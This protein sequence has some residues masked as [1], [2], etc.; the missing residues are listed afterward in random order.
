MQNGVTFVGDNL[1]GWFE[2]YTAL[3][4][5]DGTSMNV[6]G[7]T[8]L[9]NLFKGD[10]K[11]IV[12]EGLSNWSVHNVLSYDSMFE[13]CASVT[14]IDVHGWEMN[15][16]ATRVNM[17]KGL[18][19]IISLYL[20]QYISLEGTALFDS[21][22]RN[23]TMGSWM[24]AT[25][26]ADAVLY[27]DDP[28]F[29]SSDDLVRRYENP[30]GND[31]G[32]KNTDTYGAYYYWQTGVFR[33]RFGENDNAWWSYDRGTLTFGMDLPEVWSSE[34]TVEPVV[35]DRSI[36]EA[37]TIDPRPARS[38]RASRAR[39]CPGRRPRALTACST[40]GPTWSP[41]RHKPLSTT[42]SPTRST[43]ATSP[44]GSRI[45]RVSRALMASTST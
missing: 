3:E 35:T 44:S 26:D 20:G 6:S 41:S 13:G 16:N 15:V 1:A 2:N 25:K 14:S 29:G 4:H 22:T 31:H 38:S 18:D 42:A 37:D 45:T 30:A 43:R 11:L 12:V 19:S 10:D 36:Y 39:S 33:G 27:A 5:F 17:F 34:N 21:D 40:P 23:A 24:R 8:S 28:W 7:A 32:W 9:A